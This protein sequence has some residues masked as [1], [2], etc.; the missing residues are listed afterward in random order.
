MP[1][2]ARELMAAM[3]TYA[4]EVAAEPVATE[5]PTQVILGGMFGSDGEWYGGFLILDKATERASIP[6]VALYEDDLR[7]ALTEM[8]DTAHP[9]Y[10]HFDFA[11]Q[12]WEQGERE[13]PSLN[14][15]ELTIPLA[16]RVRDALRSV[17]N[18]LQTFRGDAPHS[19]Q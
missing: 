12:L 14:D 16:S 11:Y 5:S 15:A 2:D 8:T 9:Q 3:E 10:E 17:P 13:W 1:S 18:L 19:E 7:P 6:H 4:A